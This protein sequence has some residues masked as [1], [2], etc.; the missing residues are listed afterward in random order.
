MNP[1]QLSA[2]RGQDTQLAGD[3]P[4]AESFGQPNADTVDPEFQNPTAQ[5][6]PWW[7]RPSPWW[8]V[9]WHLNNLIIRSLF[10]W[11]RLL[12]AIPFTTTASSAKIAPRIEIYT[13]LVCAVHRPDAAGQEFPT[14][15][16]QNFSYLSRLSAP[17]DS[18]TGLNTSECASDPVVQAE[19]AKLIAGLPLFLPSSRLSY[20]LITGYALQS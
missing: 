13:A 4:P 16:L 6:T 19:V 11:I 7:R 5:K 12:A 14:N 15:L 2:A 3:A 10:L 17:L 8:F 18:F 20:Q 1:L 9:S